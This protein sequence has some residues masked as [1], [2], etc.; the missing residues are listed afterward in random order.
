MEIN[1]YHLSSM[2]NQVWM[3]NVAYALKIRRGGEG[4]ENR[5]T[6]WLIHQWHNLWINIY[7]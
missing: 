6:L 2:C 1:I 3:R 4:K 7:S 5:K